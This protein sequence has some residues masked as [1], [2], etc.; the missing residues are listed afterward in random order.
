MFKIKV[1]KGPETKVSKL[2]EIASEI[3]E[4]FS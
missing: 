2:F 1:T 3:Q 4:E